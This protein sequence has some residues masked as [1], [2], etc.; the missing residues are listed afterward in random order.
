[1][2]IWTAWIVDVL[3]SL[4]V[5]IYS[6]ITESTNG[7]KSELGAITLL[8]RYCLFEFLFGDDGII[9]KRCVNMNEFDELY[10]AGA[11]RRK[12]QVLKQKQKKHRKRKNKPKQVSCSSGV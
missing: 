2:G 1:M 11:S 5:L 4:W 3:T 8:I 7:K 10:K 6:T 12:K 9:I